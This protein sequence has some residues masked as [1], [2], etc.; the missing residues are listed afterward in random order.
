MNESVINGVEITSLKR[1]SDQ[2][3]WLSE[4]YRDDELPELKR[5]CSEVVNAEE[6]DKQILFFDV[7]WSNKK[8]NFTLD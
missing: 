1:F 2:R 8:I 7:K 3:G 6:N 5:L 4:I